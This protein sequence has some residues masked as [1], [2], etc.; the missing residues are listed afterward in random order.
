MFKSWTI[1]KHCVHVW[2]NN[3]IIFN[4]RKQHEI[5]STEN[6]SKNKNYC[7]FWT[8]IIHYDD[9]FHAQNAQNAEDFQFYT[10]T[11][12]SHGYIVQN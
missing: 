3:F 4:S 12:G 5:L 10:K 7:S 1:V 2:L 6:N 11:H 8:W 9:Y